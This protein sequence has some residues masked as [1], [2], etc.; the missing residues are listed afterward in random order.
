M[1]FEGVRRSS[2][3]PNLTPLIDIVFLLLVFFL[4][5]AHFVRDEGIAIQLPEAESAVASDDDLLVEV[6]VDA[7]GRIHL[8]KQEVLVDQLEARIRAALE[9]KEKKWVTLRGDRGTQ[10]QIV[11]SVLDA[12]RRAGAES[13]DVVTEK[14]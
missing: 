6:L 4:L 9:G 8:D 13:V 12:A 1:K 3:V 7:E 2:D 14:P 5:T 10:L 11:V